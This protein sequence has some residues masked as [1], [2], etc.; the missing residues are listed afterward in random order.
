MSWVLP[1]EGVLKLISRKRTIILKFTTNR[2]LSNFV[3]CVI[4][5][6]AILLMISL[7]LRSFYCQVLTRL[8]NGRS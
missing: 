1:G 2:Y 5:V 4:D 6:V 8:R 3:I 7:P